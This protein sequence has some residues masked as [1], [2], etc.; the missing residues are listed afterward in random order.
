MLSDAPVYIF[1]QSSLTP[2]GMGETR[3]LGYSFANR[4]ISF[5]TIPGTLENWVLASHPSRSIMSLNALSLGLL[6]CRSTSIP[7]EYAALSRLESQSSCFVSL[8]L[9]SGGSCNRPGNRRPDPR[10][11]HGGAIVRSDHSK[12]CRNKFRVKA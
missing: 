1:V 5:F 12:V 6:A 9:I 11:K 3:T 2:N 4:S 8:L 7:R 10:Q